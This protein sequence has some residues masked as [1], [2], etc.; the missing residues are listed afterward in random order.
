MGV[1]DRLAR[2]VMAERVPLESHAIQTRV[3]QLLPTEAPLLPESA[4]LA[5]ADSLVGLGPIEPLLRDPAVSDVLVNG[6]GAVWIESEG[7]LRPSTVRFESPGHVVAAVERVIA[8]LGLRLDRASPAVDARLPD[9]SRLHAIVPPAAVD[10]PAVAVRRF[11]ETVGDLEELAARNAVDTRG[12]EVLRGLVADRQN[13]LVAGPTGSGKTTL[14]NVLSQEIPPKERVVSV[15]DAAELRLRGHVV[16]LEGRPPNVEGAGGITL[17]DL[18][19]HAL[20]LRPDRI[21]VGEVRGP[22][23]LDLLQ[24]LSTGHEGSMSTIHASSAAEALW[25]LETLALAADSGVSEQSIARQVR[26]VVGAVVVV[27][28]RTGRRVVRSISTVGDDPEE[29]YRCP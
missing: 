1:I 25:R 18:L 20:R 12:A 11:T 5:V 13:V 26:N 29:V 7:D 4:A 3:R 17:R 27:G 23:A 24:A 15:E 8:P 9:G 28:R 21:I 2:L 19:R 10:G 22:E 14:L 6:D 16:R